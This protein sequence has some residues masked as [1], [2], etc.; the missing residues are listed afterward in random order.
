MWHSGKGKTMEKVERSVVARV[1]GGRKDEQVEHT[2]FLGQWKYSVWYYNDRHISLNILSKP[3]EHTTTRV[4]AKVNYGLWVVMM[5]QCSFITCFIIKKKKKKEPLWWGMLI[6]GETMHV[7]RQGIH[8]KSVSSPQSC[9]EPD[10]TLQVCLSNKKNLNKWAKDS[11][12][13]F[14]KKNGQ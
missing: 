8:G 2:G 12:D 7:W 3:K 11:T 1:L 9:C 10:T 13:I 5:C 6:M 4:N 14:P